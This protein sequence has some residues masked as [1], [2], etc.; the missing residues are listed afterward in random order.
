M[1]PREANMMSETL[2][3]LLGL[4][5]DATM[6]QIKAAY[7]RRALRLHPDKNHGD[8]EAEET[9]KHCSEA[10]AVLSDAKQRAAYDSELLLNS[11]PTEVVGGLLADLLGPRF[12]RKRAGHN[13]RHTLVLSLEDAARG[14]RRTVD[15]A[16]E[17]PCPV[18][19]G[20]GARP[21]G[22][23]PCSDCRGTGETPREG[24]FSLPRPCP[25]CGGRGKRIAA[26]CD[27][28]SGVGT[29][30]LAK[31][32]VVTLPP[33]V[34]D[35][36]LHVVRGA[37][38]PGLNGG[39]AGDL[40]VVV[41]VA[42]HAVFS[43]QGADLR[44]ELPIDSITACLGGHAEV[45]T[46]ESSVRMRIPPGTQSG[47]T[48]RLRGKGMPAGRGRRGDLLVCIAVETPL[49]LDEEQRSLMVAL[50]RTLDQPSRRMLPRVA[51]YRRCLSDLKRARRD[52]RSDGEP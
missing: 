18:C 48:L 17:Q 47:R 10:Y 35:G 14:V 41:Q 30:E 49:E 33:G 36:E 29:V 3:Q 7:R 37:G 52:G 40:H 19:H 16:V 20:G 34:R 22:L 39:A 11:S 24:L 42:A 50:S 1:L 46:L 2:Y 51:A 45:P 13:V 5:R 32:F 6:E 15:L 9:F 21:G 31:R 27:T 26:L 38:A 28:C 44:L 43:R 12:R 23:Q 25:G 4:P 8:R